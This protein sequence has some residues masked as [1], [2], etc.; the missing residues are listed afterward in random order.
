MKTQEKEN[1]K[2]E[3][4]EASRDF[5]QCTL[6]GNLPIGVYLITKDGDFVR[7]NSKVRH[8]LKL[9]QN[10]EDVNANINDYYWDTG[11]R[12]RMLKELE[13]AEARGG[14]LE[15]KVILFKVNGQKIWVQDYSRS[16]K[17]PR[18]GEIIGYAGCLVDVTDEESHHQ[19][20]DK[21]PVGVYK[22]DAQSKIVRVNKAFAD[23][24]GYEKPSELERIQ[25]KEL[26]VDP[27]EARRFDK[28]IMEQGFVVNEKVELF[29]KNKE[30]CYISVC[31]YK[32]MDTDGV[33]YIGREGTIQDV[34]D[35]ENYRQIRDS[36][37]V[38]TYMV[39]KNDQ[40]EDVI[41]Q[42]NKAF[43]DM[44]EYNMKDILGI[45]VKKV[46][47]SEKDYED[48]IKEITERYN[49]HEITEGIPIRAKTAKG[50]I[51]PLDVYCRILPDGAGKITGRAGIV[52][53][54]SNMVA[55]RELR[56]DIGKTLH[57]YSTALVTLEQ[58]IKPV[59]KALGPDI[60]GTNEMLTIE[61]AIEAIKEPVRNL[62]NAVSKLVELKNK[63]PER[64][65]ALPDEDW[66]TLENQMKFLDEYQTRTPYPEFQVAALHNSSGTV[67]DIYD[68]MGKGIFL[69]DLIRDFF[70]KAKELERVC[71]LIKIHQALDTIVEVDYSIR[72]FREYVIFQQRPPDLPTICKISTLIQTAVYQLHLFAQ[73]RRVEIVQEYQSCQAQVKVDERSVLRALSNL[74][75]NAIKYSWHREIGKKPW[76]NIKA[77]SFHN[78]VHVE[79]QNYGVPIAKEEIDNDLIFK[80]GYRGKYSG[81]RQ[82]MG[83]GIGLTD[84]RET[85]RNHGGD[86][87]IKSFPASGEDEY[88]YSKPFLTTAV[89]KLPI[90]QLK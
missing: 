45:E 2:E 5:Y 46:Y 41:S 66:N 34:T 49:K 52:I 78:E 62:K 68:K 69:R 37:P 6:P 28:L 80:F 90:Y 50:Q 76:I 19:M 43:A 29:K 61:K 56:D 82:R 17:A 27:G 84:A 64:R 73:Q 88:D 79:F 60:F 53:N 47:A 32:K 74:L 4:I 44:F 22:L 30:R 20:F 54:T 31:S 12:E 87:T 72:A 11:E 40:G 42:C 18:T 26:Y 71:C 15:K 83:T 9:P 33:T 48:F 24:L 63:S 85:A 14:C 39:G 81:D 58:A 77:V 86:V 67:L 10:G 8:I 35:E 7:C 21:L 23:I 25:I 59:L 3:V 75:Y 16:V 55:L 13:E 89:F 65:D 51:I 36:I 38:G 57:F 70:N 1:L